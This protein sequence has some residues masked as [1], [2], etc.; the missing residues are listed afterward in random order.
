[1][2]DRRTQSQR[3]TVCLALSG[4]ARL[5][6][7]SISLAHSP[8]LPVVR[9]RMRRCPLEN[10]T[11]SVVRFSSTAV[12]VRVLGGGRCVA[13]LLRIARFRTNSLYGCSAEPG[14]QAPMSS[15]GQSGEI[16]QVG[17]LRPL[18]LTAVWCGR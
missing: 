9:L 14:I 16:R 13:P 6:V 17:T 12:V 1:M 15:A 10:V 7:T 11:G 8:L 18:I 4:I 2:A 3:A 5:L